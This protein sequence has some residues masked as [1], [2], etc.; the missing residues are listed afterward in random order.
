M[1]NTLTEILD[2]W[3]RQLSKFYLKKK[4]MFNFIYNDIN[5]FNYCL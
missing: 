5:Y 2:E 1:Q 4:K 3:K